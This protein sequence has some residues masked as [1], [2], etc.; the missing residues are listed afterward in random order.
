MIDDNI[1]DFSFLDDEK[2]RL[3]LKKRY[4]DIRKLKSQ[5]FYHYCLILMG[6]I[7]EQLLMM[8]YYDFTGTNDLINKANSENIIS[9][10]D[11]AQLQF[12]NS[13]RNF[14]HVQEYVD[15]GVIIKET[16]FNHSFQVFKE[17]LEKLKTLF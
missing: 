13:T 1:E 7:I 14:L 4:L 5:K 6:S 2:I 12:I 16:K 3:E 11:K 15:S 17:V 8:Y 9:N 10:S